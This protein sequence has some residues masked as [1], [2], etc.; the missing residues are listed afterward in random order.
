MMRLQGNSLSIDRMCQLAQVSRAGFYRSFKEREPLQEE[1]DLRST[2]QQ[3]FLEHRGRY[4]YRRLTKELRRRD[5]G[6]P[7]TS[8]ALDADR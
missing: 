6:Q 4:G 5:S 3:I 2:M 1:L 8:A 7:Q